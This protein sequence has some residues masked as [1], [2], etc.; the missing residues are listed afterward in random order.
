LQLQV[1][2][3]TEY[4]NDAGANILRGGAFKS[5]TSPHSFQGLG[6]EGLKYLEEAIINDS[7]QIH[8]SGCSIDRVWCRFGYH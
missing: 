6:E 7:I 5:R 3:K 2:E 8:V 4:K 1:T